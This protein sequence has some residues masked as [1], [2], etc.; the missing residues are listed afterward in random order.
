MKTCLQ[1]TGFI[2]DDLKFCPHCST[3][4]Q[5]SAVSKLAGIGKGILAGSL[6]L[7]LMACYG[8]PPRNMKTEP[9]KDSKNKIS[10]EDSNARKMKE[11][12][13]NSD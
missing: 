9:V 13:G 11:N 6:S 10:E 12:S 8:P 7:T 4:V 5:T 1:C 3:E 2:P